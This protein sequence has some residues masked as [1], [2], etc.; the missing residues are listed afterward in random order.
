MLGRISILSEFS[1]FM[2]E[3][4]QKVNPFSPWPGAWR[5]PRLVLITIRFTC[6]RVLAPAST[7]V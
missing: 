7:R 3:V 5:F 6:H 4:V 2:D 1:F